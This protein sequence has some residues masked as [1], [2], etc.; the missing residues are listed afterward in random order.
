MKHKLKKV[1]KGVV[2]KSDDTVEEAEGYPKVQIEEMYEPRK[3]LKFVID[4][5]KEI[6][7]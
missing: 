6:P 1:K 2:K 7:H 4:A 3:E 5:I